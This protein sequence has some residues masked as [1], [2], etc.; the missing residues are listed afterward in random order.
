MA[1]TLE[2]ESKLHKHR[3]G[4]V[5]LFRGEILMV[6]KEEADIA[7]RSIFIVAVAFTLA[8]FYLSDRAPLAWIIGTLA[9]GNAACALGIFIVRTRIIK[10]E[11]KMFD[12]FDT[13]EQKEFERYAIKV[14][15]IKG[16]SQ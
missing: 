2:D 7:G 12:K 13:M 1:W 4:D 8:V 11:T 15:D 16:G 3:I 14:E 9:L 6:A 5:D 10:W